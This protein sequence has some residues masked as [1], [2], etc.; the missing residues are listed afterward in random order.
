[1]EPYKLIKIINPLD[2]KKKTVE[3]KECNSLSLLDIRNQE[4]PLDLEFIVSVNGLVIPEENYAAIIIKPTDCII[5]TPKIEGGD[6]LRTVLMVAI[7]AVAVASQQYYLAEIGFE[8]MVITNAGVM[9]YSAGAQMMGV[10]IATGVTIAGSM[11]V[12]ALLPV[13]SAPAIAGSDYSRSQTYSWSPS[14]MQQQGGAIPRVYGAHRMYGNVISSYIDTGEGSSIA[15][16]QTLNMLI[17]LAQGPIKSITNILI[18]DQASV[19][20]SG[21]KLHTRLGYLGDT[22]VAEN[23]QSVIPL[24]NSTKV[25]YIPNHRVSYGT[26]YT[27]TTPDNDFDGLEIILSFP[28][29]LF[30]SNDGGTLS[31]VAVQVACEIR[32]VTLGESFRYVLFSSTVDQVSATGGYWSFGKIVYKSVTDIDGAWTAEE[33]WYEITQGSNPTVP[34]SHRSGDADATIDPEA[35]W[36]WKGEASEILTGDL[37]NY[38]VISAADTTAFTFTKK[39][40]NLSH[41]VYE[42][43]ITKV[44]ADKNSFRYGDTVRLGSVVEVYNDD[45]RYPK[46]ALVGIQALA[47]E[48][49]SGSIN[50]SCD[51][52]GSLVRVYRTNTWF[53]EYS[54]NPAWVAFDI[55]TQPVFDDDLTIAR[56]D[57]YDISY[58][59]VPSF[60]AWADY[61]DTLVDNGAGGTEKRITFNGVI[62]FASNVWDTAI[63]VCQM[64]YASPV[65]T[66][67]TIRIVIDQARTSTQLFTVGNII[68]DSF[69]E[70]FLS[71]SERAG[72]LEVEF[73]D[74][75][76]DYERTTLTLVDTTASRPS[77]KASKALVGITKSSEANR[78]G[79]RYLAYNKYQ[80]RLIEW[81]ADVDA[82]VC[83]LGDRVDLSHDVPQWGFGGRVISATS[84][85]VVVDRTITIAAGKTGSDYT[86][87]LRLTNDTLVTKTLAVAMTPGDYT[88]LTISDTF[89]TG[90]PVQYDPYVVG[91]TA[92]VVKPVIVIGLRKAS[93]QTVGIT[94]VDYYDEVYSFE[95]GKVFSTALNYSSINRILSITNVTTR[96]LAYVDVESGNIVRQVFIDFEVS[97][98]AIYKSAVV[99]VFEINGTQ[100]SV[101]DILTSTTR[102]AV[103]FNAKPLTSYVFAV[104]GVNSYNE[105]SPEGVNGAT[106]T[107]TIT[108]T[109]DVAFIRSS[110]RG[111]VFGLQ[112]VGA[113][114]NAWSFAGRDVTFQWSRT[115]SIDSSGVAGEE[116]HG[117]ATGIPDILFKHYLIQ[118]Y[119]S[120]GTTRRGNAIVTKEALFTYSLA[121]NLEDGNG[122]PVAEFMIAVDAVNI[123]NEITDQKA[124]ILAVNTVPATV[125]GLTASAIVGG[126]QFRWDKSVDLDLRSYYY[127]ITVGSGTPEAW[128]DVENNFVSRLLTAAEIALY[129]GKCQIT[130]DVKAKDWYGQYSATAATAYETSD[131]ISDNLFQLV[132]DVDTGVTGTV[133]TLY[134]GVINSGGVVVT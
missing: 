23:L 126:V 31:P 129:T 78:V 40:S 61:C 79:Y 44:S 76:Q 29:G 103:F 41:G 132:A 97:T 65:W 13:A 111:K 62:D 91:L 8:E 27:Y 85:T 109:S 113:D 35:Y 87:K 88:T 51:V 74:Q 83:E 101:V 3:F 67:T 30:Y 89:T 5:F 55:F 10:A 125:T 49:I 18:N 114:A 15:K 110:F 77:N 19:T 11:L 20:Y 134:D 104:Q 16:N 2:H 56:Y 92:V 72:E 25:T 119:E 117:A 70:S 50:F 33:Q 84:N 99:R 6:V 123:F 112:I 96:E 93:D 59:D 9:A 45:Y 90:I 64:S 86:I 36:D 14:T 116:T 130:I 17:G 37:A 106:N 52:E 63:T 82:I 107:G 46:L 48:Q 115:S 7:I 42:I 122:V 21:L 43:K 38:A 120:D 94:A 100:A 108:T 73:T 24:F 71:L 1:M 34:S 95:S 80:I 127:R 57:G 39:I 12:N 26:P 121:K 66:G 47:S 22:S 105:Y 58:M 53:T 54:N 98:N 128:K 60:A 102:K 4:V 133:S 118:I 131:T 124:I 32:N 81:E 68:E 69:K 75:N 28:Q